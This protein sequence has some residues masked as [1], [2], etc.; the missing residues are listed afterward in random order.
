MNKLTKARQ[1]NIKKTFSD[2][3][4]DMVPFMSQMRKLKHSFK[5]AKHN[6]KMKQTTAGKMA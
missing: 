5:R 6:K 1:E 4:A 2:D 3:A